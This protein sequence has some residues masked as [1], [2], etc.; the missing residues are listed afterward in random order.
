M[1]GIG[2]WLKVA[3]GQRGRP[4][5]VQ[6]DAKRSFVLD[7]KTF[8]DNVNIKSKLTFRPGET[9]NMTAVADPRYI[10]LTIY[11]VMA[12]LPEKPM[13]PRVADDRVGYFLTV[14]KDFA[15]KDKTLMEQ[16][17]APAAQPAAMQT[18]PI[19]PVDL[20]I[21]EQQPAAEVPAEPA[22]SM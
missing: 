19:D 4:G 9:P 10:P 3:V 22:A 15:Q 6:L 14:H 17:P 8:P 20:V 2:E 16:A 12:K 18:Q 11:C 5:R 7:A 13:T 1:S 21:P